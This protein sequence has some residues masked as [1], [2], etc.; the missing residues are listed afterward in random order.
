MVEFTKIDS[1]EFSRV[2][3]AVRLALL[4]VTVK[5]SADE[6][7]RAA[8]ALRFDLRDLASLTAKLTVARAAKPGQTQV[9]GRLEAALTQACV[10]T[11]QPVEARLAETFEAVFRAASGDEM[12]VELAPDLDEN[13]P[14]PLG[15]EGLD[16][17]ELVAQ[18]LAVALDPYPR[19]G[20]AQIGA[21]WAA[22]PQEEILRQSPFAVLKGM[23]G[24]S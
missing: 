24:K 10:V 8:L 4:P 3:P 18:Q 6:R 13:P 1:N 15:P 11:L 22:D 19:S 5:I 14:E 23:K 9:K 12:P 17:G 21:E 7:E 16:L 2:L 20:D